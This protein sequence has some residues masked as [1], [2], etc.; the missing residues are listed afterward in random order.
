MMLIVTG[1]IACGKSCFKKYVEMKHGKSVVDAD[2][3]YK[4]V[5][6]SEVFIEKFHDLFGESSVDEI[7]FV[8]AEW[9]SYEYF[10]HHCFSVDFLCS[11]RYDIVIIPEFFKFQSFYNKF[12]YDI[13]TIE[14]SVNIEHVAKRDYFR[15]IGL[16]K[17]IMENQT[18]SSERLSK[19]KY[20][21]W[22]DGTML[23]FQEKIDDFMRNYYD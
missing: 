7:A 13:L 16:S 1:G 5:K 17:R 11:Y 6:S 20:N 23:E 4:I 19:S 2:D 21:I 22:N 14:R 12:Q 9:K 8:H 15:D 3:W 18:S 10:V